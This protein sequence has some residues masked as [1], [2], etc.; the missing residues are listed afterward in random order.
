[1][2]PGVVHAPGPWVTFEIQKPQDD[3]HLCA[4]QLGKQL[5]NEELQ[6]HRE[7]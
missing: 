5:S 6:I 4:W 3:F 7:K 1:M 2:L